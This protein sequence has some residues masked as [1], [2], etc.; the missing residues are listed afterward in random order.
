MRPFEGCIYMKLGLF[1]MKLVLSCNSGVYSFFYPLNLLPFLA[2]IVLLVFYF[3][4]FLRRTKKG[5]LT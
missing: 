5:H 3:L 1:Y 2:I 4:Q